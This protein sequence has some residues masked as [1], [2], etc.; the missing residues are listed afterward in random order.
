MTQQI[1]GQSRKADRVLERM[2]T[3]GLFERDLQEGFT[4][5]PGPGGQNVNKVATCV[6]LQHV[7]SGKIVKCHEYRTQFANRIRAREMLA[8][9][10]IE[11]KDK[12]R[13]EAMRN[14]AKERARRR[15]RSA[16][17]KEK[18]LEEK[19][20]RARQKQTRRPVSCREDSG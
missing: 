7:P 5:S 19:K 16:A 3:A 2:R 13:A 1:Q 14:R 10:F 20:R 4:A 8:D 11:S 18:M 15:G 9:F 17:G 6:V 12:A